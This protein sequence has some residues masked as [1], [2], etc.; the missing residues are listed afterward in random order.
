MLINTPRTAT[1]RA[2]EEGTALIVIARNN[3]DTILRDNPT[4]GQ[5]ILREMAQRLKDTNERIAQSS[6][7]HA[8]D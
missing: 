6:P 8:A 5:S 1:A 7:G 3:F 2:T 4:I